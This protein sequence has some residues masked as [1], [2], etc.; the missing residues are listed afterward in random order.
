MFFISEVS[1]LFFILSIIWL[2]IDLILKAFTNTNN[3]NIF[4][5]TLYGFF[6]NV[7]IGAMYQLIPNSIMKKPKFP[8]L[9]FITL[10][11]SVLNGFIMFL[12]Y[13]GILGNIYFSISNIVLIF[14]FLI[15]ISTALKIP[16]SITAKFLSASLIFLTINA[17]EMLFYAF[18]K[19]NIFFLIHTFTIGFVINAV[20]GVELA[21]VPLLYMEPLNMGLANKLFWV[22]QISASILIASFYIFDLRLIYFAGIL[23][24]IVLGFFVYLI[25]K[26][27]ENR[28]FPKNITYTLRYFFLGLGF[29]LLGV[30]F[31]LL[32]ASSKL[33]PFLHADVMIYGFGLITVLGGIFHFMPRILW[34]KYYAN[35]VGEQN[36][37]PID[38]MI[39]QNVVKNLLPFIGFGLFLLIVFESNHHLKPVGDI[40]YAFLTA[41]SLY[42]FIRK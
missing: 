21:L 3:I 6:L 40:I 15:H 38:A 37:P 39:N 31:G 22:H 28:K 26:T 12:W 23:E 19:I 5:I 18:N 42:A 27:I 33:E 25:Y 4:L 41:Y 8:K 35:K 34:N 13:F 29:L 17:L 9:S 2:I 10:G 1:P 36:T 14:A 30:S 16:N 32:V 24:F 20:I 11:L 7:I